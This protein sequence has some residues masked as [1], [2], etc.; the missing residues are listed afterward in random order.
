MQAEKFDEHHRDVQMGEVTAGL[1]RVEGHVR[2][3]VPLLEGSRVKEAEA[4]SC[5]QWQE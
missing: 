2:P 5:R 3:G 1:H 4:E